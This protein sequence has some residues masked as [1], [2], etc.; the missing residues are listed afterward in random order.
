MDMISIVHIY[1][2][3]RPVRIF[4][5]CPDIA[6]DIASYVAMNGRNLS[7][8]LIKVPR[9]QLPERSDTEIQRANQWTELFWFH[10]AIA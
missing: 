1:C 6:H 8:A 3:D 5:G 7:V 4:V 2:D 9:D 10:R